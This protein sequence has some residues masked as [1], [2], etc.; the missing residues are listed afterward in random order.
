M[1][2]T[3]R[4]LGSEAIE[5]VRRT[6][7]AAR[8]RLLRTVTTTEEE[9]ATLEAH[10]PGAPIEDAA[11]EEVVGILGRLGVLERRELEE[12]DAAR[13]RLAAGA[14]GTCEGCGGAIP[15]PRLRAVPTARLCVDCQAR[16]ERPAR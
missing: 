16:H 3:G 12:I 13:A 10:E 1:A 8:A 11:R 14:F 15:L 4:P 7:L 2:G 6:L 9:L 5:E